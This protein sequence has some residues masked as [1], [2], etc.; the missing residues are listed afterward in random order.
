LTSVSP[1]KCRIEVFNDVLLFDDHFTKFAWA[2]SPSG[3]TVFDGDVVALTVQAGQTYQNLELAIEFNPNTFKYFMVRLT[4]G[5]GRSKVWVRRKS[6]SAWLQVGTPGLGL[7]AFDITSVCTTTVDRISLQAYGSPG[8][9]AEFDYAVIAKETYQTLSEDDLAGRC[10]IKNRLLNV[11]VNSASLLLQNFENANRNKVKK[12]ACILIWLS[13]DAGNLGNPA[14]KAFGGDVISLEDQ[15]LG[16]GAYYIQVECMGHAQEVLKPPAHLNKTYSATNGRTIIEAA[17]ALA[18]YVAKHPTASKWF[19]NTG[20]SGSTDDRI[21][22]THNI[23]YADENPLTVMQEILEKAAN[24]SSVRGFDAYE[25]SSGVIVGH[26]RNSLDFVSPISSVTPIAFARTEDVHQVV[27]KQVVYGAY[28]FAVGMETWDDSII[29]WTALKGSIWL[30]SPPYVGCD[31]DENREF[32][33][34]RTVYPYSVLCGDETKQPNSITK[35]Y[36]QIMLSLSG[37]GYNNFDIILEAPDESNYFAHEHTNIAYGVN[38]EQDLSLGP[39]YTGTGKTWKAYGSPDW[40]QI[41]KVRFKGVIQFGTIA[42]L[43]ATVDYLKVTPLRTRGQSSDAT[44]Q[45]AYGVREGKPVVDE[46]LKTDAECAARA[47]GVVVELKNPPLL[48]KSIM[49]DGDERYWPGD[50][51]RVQ[52]SDLSIDDTY[53]MLEVELVL[54]DSQWFNVLGISA[55]DKKLDYVFRLLK[56]G[57]N[58][59]GRKS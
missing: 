45:A 51:Q 55:E 41:K 12:F 47:A 48:L 50:R 16:Y 28:A 2:Q 17:L 31:V 38:I 6:D 39:D 36:C 44:S 29:R 56:S 20:S 19:D 13:R 11:G 40:E 9:D 37:S 53:R 54:E 34:Y 32:D 49:V 52:V 33:F 1:P 43:Y 42:E 46:A 10:S 14:Y 58:L 22:S 8:V 15:G 26:L 3:G 5:L 27:N 7:N 24:P 59:L 23:S 35:L 30:G 57:E 4:S 25:Q 18:A 21:D